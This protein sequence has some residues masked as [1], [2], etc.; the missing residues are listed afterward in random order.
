MKKLSN[1]GQLEDFANAAMGAVKGEDQ[2]E[3]KSG[4]LKDF[5]KKLEQDNC[6]TVQNKFQMLGILESERDDDDDAAAPMY[7]FDDNKNG[8]WIKDEAVVDSGGV[9]CVTSRKGASERKRRRHSQQDQEERQSNNQ[10]D[11][12]VGCPKKK[13]SVQGRNIFPVAYQRRELARNGTSL[14]QR[15]IHASSR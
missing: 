3:W 6:I 7:V 13:R 10:L 15:T 14:P 11:D 9:V 4:R 2:H 1:S 5:V 12:R 8:R